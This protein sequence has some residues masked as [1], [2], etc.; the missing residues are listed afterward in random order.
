[1]NRK[2]LLLLLLGR[3]SREEGVLL[4]SCKVADL[5]SLDPNNII[6]LTYQVGASR[7]GKEGGFKGSIWANI[8]MNNGA[9]GSNTNNIVIEQTARW[10]NLIGLTPKNMPPNLGSITDWQRL[11]Q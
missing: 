5:D 8:Q 3:Y 7:A 1:M 2:L 10:E 6:V 4:D 11:E 9:C